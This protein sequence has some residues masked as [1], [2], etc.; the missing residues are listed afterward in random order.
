MNGLNY[1]QKM[2]FKIYISETLNKN[3]WQPITN[4]SVPEGVIKRQIWVNGQ[5]LPYFKDTKH[6]KFSF[7]WDF[8]YLNIC[9]L[10]ENIISLVLQFCKKHTHTQCLSYTQIVLF[11]VLLMNWTSARNHINASCLFSFWRIVRSLTFCDLCQKW[12]FHTH[13]LPPGWKKMSVWLACL[14]HWRQS[15][16]KNVSTSL[17]VSGTK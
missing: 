11:F 5:V 14:T 1:W 16:L 4:I 7:V 17:K 3:L 9:R 6:S 15:G 12:P 2:G 8:Y 10:F 13:S